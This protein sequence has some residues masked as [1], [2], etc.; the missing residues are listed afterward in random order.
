MY[1]YICGNE[2]VTTDEL[3]AKVSS[4]ASWLV[5]NIPEGKSV[6]I[7]GHKSVVTY[8]FI[9]ACL[10]CGVGYIPCDTILS[11]EKI[12]D[13]IDR[14]QPAAVLCTEKN[15]RL[16]FRDI[17]VYEYDLLLSVCDNGESFTEEH[18]K[19]SGMAYTV[20][21]SGTTGKRHAV[22]INRE[23][24]KAFTS[25]FLNI[26]ALREIAPRVILNTANFSF[27][28][29]VA[30][31]VYCS[32][33]KA[34]MVALTR[35]ETADMSSLLKRMGESHAEMTVMTPSFADLCL[36]DRAFN[37]CLMPELKLFFFCGE[38]LKTNTARKL[39]QRFPDCRIINAYGPS[40][41]TCAVTAVEIT[42]AMLVGKQLP[43]GTAEG[44]SVQICLARDGE[45][46]L[47]GKA[48]SRGYIG[49][50]SKRF[51]DKNYYCTGDYGYI[52]NG[53]LYYSG[54]AERQLR[55]RGYRIEIDELESE[56]GRIDGIRQCAVTADIDDETP[57]LTAFIVCSSEVSLKHLRDELRRSIPKNMM[58]KKF[59][60]LNSL[61]LDENQKLDLA[62][63][64]K[65]R[66]AKEKT[67]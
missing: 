41:A 61:P 50:D 43:I 3:A 33:R 10:K 36:S 55:L 31:I 65:L 51:C 2:K 12:R 46:H 23:N 34:A 4:A 54:R 45:I 56:L 8:V 9:L 48:V 25:W 38:I 7:Y 30:D 22:P 29:S 39:F 20:F 14:T 52:E 44:N 62:K 40:E 53:L 16:G 19:S 11:A 58:P 32:E 42:P 5:K 21:T 63:L 17:P 1:S 26:P 60:F 47:V 27:D 28:L 24:L 13:N 66:E 49:E 64:A 67:S 35:N 57:S 15:S 37:Y 18:I 59:V 6:L